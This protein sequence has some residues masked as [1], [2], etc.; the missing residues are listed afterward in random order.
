MAELSFE[1]PDAGGDAKLA[2]TIADGE[3]QEE[4]VA[5]GPGSGLEGIQITIDDDE[6]ISVAVGIR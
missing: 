4:R 2:V 6:D 5:V 3:T 1:N